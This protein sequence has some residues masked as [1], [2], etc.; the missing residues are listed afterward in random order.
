[1]RR[2]RPRGG[3][4]QRN[5]VVF[6]GRHDVS[7]LTTGGGE[8]GWFLGSQPGSKNSMIEHTTTAA[9]TGTRQCAGLI[10]GWGLRDLGLFHG[11]GNRQ[12][13]SHLSDIFYAGAIGEE[14]VMPDAV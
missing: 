8:L 9:G 2:R 7:I 1:M 11:R 6:P 12:Q 10:G 14:A 4:S 5:S 3:P 13:L